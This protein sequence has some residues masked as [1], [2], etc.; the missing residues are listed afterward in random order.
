[1]GNAESAPGPQGRRDK[2]KSKLHSQKQTPE[3]AQKSTSNRYASSFNRTQFLNHS[4]SGTGATYSDSKDI[5]SS[6][7]HGNITV[8]SCLT[9]EA[10]ADT[11][12]LSCLSGGAEGGA[13][14]V[15]ILYDVEANAGRQ[16]VWEYQR[17]RPTLGWG[18]ANFEPTDLPLCA[19]TVYLPACLPACAECLRRC[20][21][22][23]L[24]LLL[25]LVL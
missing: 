23:S 13:G 11:E 5:N 14:S 21:V 2:S 1:M 3:Q 19:A 10:S 17:F 8:F 25:L 16:I 18:A 12:G 22:C 6:N 7:N 20:L 4:V 15:K 9:D 24:L